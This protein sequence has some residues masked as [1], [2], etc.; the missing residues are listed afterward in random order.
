MALGTNAK[1]ALIKSAP[2]FENCSKQELQSIAQIADELDIR[3]GKVLIREGER[4]REFFVIVKGEVE[5]SELCALLDRPLRELAGTRLERDRVHR[6]D[7]RQAQIERELD[8]EREKLC[9]RHP[10]QV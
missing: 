6:A 10:H 2:L 9:L 3:E 7:P 5:R 8:V 4:G 1:I